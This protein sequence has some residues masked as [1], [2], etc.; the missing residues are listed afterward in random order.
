MKIA[1][2]GT[3]NV[4]R[5]LAG[6]FGRAGH[7][8]TLAARDLAKTRAVADEVGATAAEDARQASAGA[9]VVVLAVPYASIAEVAAEIEPVAADRVVVDVSNPLT[10]DYGTLA[11]EGGPS[12]AEELSSRLPAARIV[13][14]FNTLFATRQAD[15][16]AGGTTIDGLYATDDQRA[17]D[18]I[19]EL[20]D[21]IGLRPVNAGP[22]RRARQLEAMGFL[23]IALQMANGGDWRS[24]FVLVGAPA[25]ATGTPAAAGR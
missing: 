4:G 19:A 1:I 10:A 7:D 21:S 9:D 23:N 11:T 18:T 5:A 24:A 15:P 6:A 14:A 22:L 16:T 17:A 25:G 12:A 20:E 3:G 13:K 8:V 2:I